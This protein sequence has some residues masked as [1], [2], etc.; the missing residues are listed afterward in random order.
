MKYM[1][2]I[3]GGWYLLGIQSLSC[4][5]LTTW[6]ILSCMCLLWLINKI[7]LIRMAVHIELLGA[8]L[9]EHRVRHGQVS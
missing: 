1:K 9:T 5:C 7:I 2:I 8:D 3:G 6:G 4:I